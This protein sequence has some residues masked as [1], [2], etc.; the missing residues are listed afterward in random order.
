[1]SVVEPAPLIIWGL[2]QSDCNYLTETTNGK[3]QLIPLGKGSSVV[4]VIGYPRAA[5]S[6]QGKRMEAFVE[7]VMVPG[8]GLDSSTR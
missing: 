7:K 8:A 6:K 2:Q 3:E 1:M 5:A 4:T